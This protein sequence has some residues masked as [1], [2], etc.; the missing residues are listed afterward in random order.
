M[1]TY[2]ITIRK[3]YEIMNCGGNDSIKPAS[4]TTV[5]KVGNGEYFIF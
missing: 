3:Q 2:T 5:G 1:Y 4:L